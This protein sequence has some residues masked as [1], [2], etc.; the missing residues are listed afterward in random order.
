M[1]R[2]ATAEDRSTILELCGSSLGWSEGD[3]N[4]A[5]FA[6]KHDGNVFGSSPGWVA[7]DPDDRI[8]GVR[9]FMRWRFREPTG[10]VVAAVRAVDTATH[11]DARGRGVF[12]R[13]TLGALPELER[14]QI[15]FVFNTP[16]DRSRPGYLKMGWQTVGKVPLAVRPA[17]LSTS[18]R[19]SAA[20]WTG[21][22]KWGVPTDAGACPLEAFADGQAVTALL[23]S[24]PTPLGLSTDLSV[25]YLRW[26]YGFE[27]LGYRVLLLGDD[28]AHG[29]IIFRLCQRGKRLDAVICQ[30]L[31][32]RPRAM[33]AVYASL[34]RATGADLLVRAQSSLLGRG[35]FVRVSHLGPI[36]TWKP[37]VRGTV[38]VLGDLSLTSGDLELF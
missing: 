36:L 21:A 4:E 16:N 28:L 8:L 14:Q 3:P 24:L 27:P 18:L 6:W 32:P 33:A 26:R 11:P 9:Y 25:A 17:R 35:L 22:A 23:S 2:R 31:V 10:E 30:E 12:R 13:L 5:F 7:V 19:P 15:G 29:A 38:P 37:L 1:V 34:A 20:G